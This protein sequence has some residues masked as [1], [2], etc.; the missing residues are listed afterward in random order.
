MISRKAPSP[1]TVAV[2]EII[3][4]KRGLIKVNLLWLPLATYLS[5]IK[6][7]K[8]QDAVLLFFLIF[9]SI[10]CWALGNI[11]ANDL[12]DF[13]ADF[14]AGKQR[15]ICALRPQV[16]RAVV[17]LI[18]AVGLGIQFFEGS[19]QS[20]CV[21]AG[22]MA[23]GLGYSIKPFRFKEHGAWGVLA[24]SLACALAYASVPYF[25]ARPELIWLVILFPVVLLDKWVNLHFHQILDY[26]AD[27]GRG[28]NTLAVRSGQPGARKWLTILSG[29]SS[30]LFVFAF[31]HIARQFPGWFAAMGVLGGAVLAVV[32][33]FARAS[34]LRPYVT[35]SLVQELPWFYLG[36]TFALF[37]LLPAL[38]FFRLAILDDRMWVIFAVV[39]VL[40]GLE[41]LY[42]LRYQY[43]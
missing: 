3:L 42:N 6:P 1:A 4:G 10:A 24:Y 34:K 40:L 13:Q 36:T 35:S 28:I 11:L 37:R 19:W 14:E 27:S 32:F 15:W 2:R 26:D 17:A 39:V 20:P 12:C 29:L 5:F 8:R 33:F 22:A 21:Y 38:L 9:L 23:L 7:E 41:S 18:F 31:F 43:E 16:G 30:V 25:W